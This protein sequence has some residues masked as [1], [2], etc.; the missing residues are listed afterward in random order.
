MEKIVSNP[1]LQHLA[2]KV[3]W[4]LDIEDL[5]F[6]AK[7]N[8]SCKEILQNPMFCLRKFKHLSKENRK[9][10][11]KAMQSVKNSDKGIAIIS[12]LKW[13]WKKEASVDLP[14]YSS[15]AVQDDF[16]KKI[17]ESCKK[18]RWESSD[19]DTEIVKILAPLTDN[20]NAP[21]EN[22][23]TPIYFAAHKGHT[24][25]VKILT[26]LTDNPNT[27]DKD[28]YTPIYWAARNGYTEIFKI[29]VPL[30]DNP[31]A[32]NKYGWTPISKAA[33]FGHSEILKILTH[34]KDNPDGDAPN[35]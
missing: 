22:G 9:D 25:I 35:K 16:R 6:C 23:R 17:L 32:P 28:G 24:E 10:W 3:F 2:E 21:D 26:P 11:I 14:C 8:Q 33:V 34:L 29:L 19:E 5:K 31:N 13:N 4:N 1:G 18:L 15:P 20:P 30:T 12:Y 27:S 7:I